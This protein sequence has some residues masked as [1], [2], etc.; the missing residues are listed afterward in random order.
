MR[1]A[2]IQGASRRHRKAGLTRRDRKARPAPDLVNRNFA[3]ETG[4]AWVA[5]LT[6]VRTKAGA[7]VVDVTPLQLP[8]VVNGGLVSRTVD[9]VNRHHPIEFTGDSYNRRRRSTSRP[10]RT[11]RIRIVVVDSC[12]MQRPF[13]DE[14]KQLAARRTRY[15]IVENQ[16]ISHNVSPF[17]DPSVPPQRRKNA[18]SM[19]KTR[20]LIS[21]DAYALRAVGR[22]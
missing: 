13:L 14:V 9:E 7:A 8:V 6:Y 22:G 12:L 11:S 19:V 15:P 4:S 2:G 18:L 21:G 16:K 3:A 17:A 20:M 10:S 1:E 5:D